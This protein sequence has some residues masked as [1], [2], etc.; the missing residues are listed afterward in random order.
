VTT[1]AGVRD[2]AQLYVATNLETWEAKPPVRPDQDEIC[3]P[4][5][6]RRLDPEYYAWLRSRMALAQKRYERGRL[7][8]RQYED[9]RQRFNAVHFWAVEHFGEQALREAMRSLDPTRYSPPMVKDSEEPSPPPPHLCLTDGD[10]RFTEPVSAETVAKVD[11]IRDQAL[12]LGWS[13]AQLY[14]NRG[15]YSFPCGEDY[16]LVCFLNGDDRVGEITPQSIEIISSRGSRLRFYNRNVDQP[17]LRHVSQ[18][19]NPQ[20]SL[21]AFARFP[22]GS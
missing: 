14:Q 2:G 10:W 9:L 7:P 17:W 21:D 13:E 1:E 3:E 18:S 20:G 4:C 6:F 5:G 16:G 22:V 11:A 15:R 12:A 19:A 8:S